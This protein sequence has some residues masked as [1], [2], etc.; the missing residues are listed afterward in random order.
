MLALGYP[1]ADLLKTAARLQPFA[2]VWKCSLRQAKRRW[3]WITAYAGCTGKSLTGGA[4][5]L[6]GQLWCVFGCG[7][8]R[9]K[10]KRPLMAQLPKSLLMWRW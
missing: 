10:G 6:C 1:L 8:D 5:A 3:W 9:D 4:S 7:G 2:D